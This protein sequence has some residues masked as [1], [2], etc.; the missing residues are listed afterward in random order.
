MKISWPFLTVM[1][2]LVTQDSIDE[3]YCK[4]SVASLARLGLS[5]L[6]QPLAHSP[7]VLCTCDCCPTSFGMLLTGV[8]TSLPSSTLLRLQH[9]TQSSCSCAI[10]SQEVSTIQASA[11][12]VDQGQ[13]SYISS[14]S[15]SILR[16]QQRMPRR[17]R[18]LARMSC[19]L[20]S[21]QTGPSSL[22]GIPGIAATNWV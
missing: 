8:C 1:N 21:A 11:N 16:I 17:C 9:T 15:P 22:G 18:Q 19:T 6:L 14:V 4:S 10:T 5:L 13:R 3:Y 12:D 2:T 20:H 7:T